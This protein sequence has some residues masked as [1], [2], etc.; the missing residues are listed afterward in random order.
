MP[1]VPQ[2]IPKPQQ[3][4]T[5]IGVRSLTQSN[6]PAA[7][8]K[9]GKKA[10]SGK[11]KDAASSG[12]DRVSREEQNLLIEEVGEDPRHRRGPGSDHYD[13][14]EPAAGHAT[15][16][17]RRQG[18]AFRI[19]DDGRTL[20][21]HFSE[22]E[23][24]NLQDAWLLASLA[25]V[26]TAQPAALLQRVK[27][28][29]NERFM[30]RLDQRTYPVSPEF[31]S[32]GYAQPEPKGQTDTLWVALFEKAFA[33][34]SA[35]SYAELEAGNPAQALARLVTGETRRHRVRTNVEAGEQLTQL[36]AYRSGEH[37]M[38]LISRTSNVS[39]PFVADHAYAVVDVTATGEVALYNPWGTRRGTRS[40]DSVLHRMPW[41]EAR[42][43]FEFLYVGGMI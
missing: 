30:V 41:D 3:N 33:L 2:N 38:V 25:A 10:R 5:E 21:P 27:A 28:G 31:P 37:P 39:S 15:T 8:K 36:R 11:A 22:V 13:D 9:G 16:M 20:P 29:R 6:Q 43:A 19:D 18:R 40:L 34:E 24:G 35:C 26:A 4:R 32:E 1:I 23:Q 14:L 7:L 42:S 12:L 17:M